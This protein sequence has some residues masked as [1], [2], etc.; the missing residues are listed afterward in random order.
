MKNITF[1]YKDNK[2]CYSSPVGLVVAASEVAEGGSPVL[3]LVLPVVPEAMVEA[4]VLNYPVVAMHEVVAEFE[5]AMEIVP[6]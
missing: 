2:N 3:S 5:E 6:E 4:L 1:D